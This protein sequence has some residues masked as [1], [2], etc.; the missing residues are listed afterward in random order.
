[1]R[2]Q[3]ARLAILCAV[4]SATMFGV[5]EKRRPS[6][7]DENAIARYVATINKVLDQFGGPDWNENIDHAIAHPMLNRMDDRPLD[8]DEIFERTYDVR[9]DSKRYQTMVRPRQQRLALEKDAAKRDLERAQIEDLMHLQVEVHCHLP[10]VPTSTEPDRK[11]DPKVPGATFVH[12][13]RNNPFGHGVAFIL[14][15][16]NGRAGKWDET[17]SVYRNAFVHPPNTP[18]IENLEIRI[19]GPPDRIRELLRK[20][21]WKQVN[22]ALTL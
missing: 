2:Q 17:N 10:Q 7:A 12:Q 4:V 6:D 1:M 15:F 18:Y 14:F 22:A 19:S 3:I 8:L 11:R 5:M 13:D 9:P 21:N 16:S 20:V